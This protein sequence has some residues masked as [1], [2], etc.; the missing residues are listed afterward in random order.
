MTATYLGSLTIGDALPG[1]AAVSLAGAAGISAALPD[2]LARLAALQAF[3]PSPVSFTAQ[4]ALAQ[5]MVTSIE[6][7]ISLGVPA[8][9]IAAQIAA[10]AALIASLLATVSSINVQLDLIAD[11]QALLGAAGVHGVAYVGTV[12]GFASDVSSALSGVPGLSS[13]DACNAITLLTTVPATWV[14]LAQIM[15]V[16]P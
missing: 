11:F 10:I 13:G 6:L 12:G 9:S 5:Q 2:I 16:S 7:S 3:A 1:A 15:K 4:L 8:P 14:A